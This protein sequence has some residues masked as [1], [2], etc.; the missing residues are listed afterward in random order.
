MPLRE[1]GRFPPLNALRAFE[2]AARHL[3]FK[4]AARELFVT[5]G[6]VSHQVKLLEDH[7][8]VALF[9]RLTRALELTPEAQ[10]ML[11]KVREGLASLQE[12]VERVRAREES[13]ALTVMAPP[14]FATRWLVP[15]LAGFTRNFPDVELHVASRSDMIDAGDEELEMPPPNGAP[16]MMVR[17]GRGHYPGLKVDEVFSALYVPVCSPKLLQGP[18][19]LR[20]PSDLRWHTLLHDDT[21][22]EEGARPSWDDWLESVGVE[23][24]DATRG[25]H[26]SDA[27]LA[28]DAA[29]EGMG[30]TLAMKPLVRPDIEAGRLAMPFDI[31][32]PTSYSYYL[33]TSENDAEKES[34]A[35]FRRW[36]LAEAAP[37]RVEPKSKATSDA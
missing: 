34:V 10:A 32:A 29:I 6:A 31:T 20:T 25:P 1:G 14:G 24:V 26:F 28:L 18:H 23:D 13:A 8:G 17:F 37:E 4:K 35:A 7:L 33:L 3:S 9:R 30:V 11:P 15:R 5:P 19:P 21:V 2:A 16:F 22:V 36:I 12:A 27:S